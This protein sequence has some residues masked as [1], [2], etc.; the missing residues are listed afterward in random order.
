MFFVVPGAQGLLEKMKGSEDFVEAFYEGLVV[1]AAGSGI[2][3]EVVGFVDFQGRFHGPG[4]G[5]V[6]EV[7]AFAESPGDL[8]VGG[9]HLIEVQKVG[10]RGAF[11]RRHARAGRVS[12]GA[13]RRRPRAGGA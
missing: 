13:R 8:V 2:E 6:D 4:E 1:G 7:G 9:R 10:E 12:P 11:R 3:D 5:G